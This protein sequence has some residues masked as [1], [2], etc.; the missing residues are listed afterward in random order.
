MLAGEIAEL[1][2]FIIAAL[3]RGTDPLAPPARG[4]GAEGERG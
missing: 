3:A 2:P 1:A 4:R